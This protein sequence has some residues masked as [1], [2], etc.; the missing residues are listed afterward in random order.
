MKNN[1]KHLFTSILATGLLALSTGSQAA[2]VQHS[3]DLIHDSD[4]NITWMQNAN[5]NGPMTW[6]EATDWANNLVYGGYDDWR[7]P[8]YDQLNHLFYDELGA[9]AWNTEVIKGNSNYGLFSNFQF[10]LYWTA[11]EALGSWSDYAYTYDTVYGAHNYAQPKD[12]S[13]G[14]FYAWAIRGNDITAPAAVPVPAA[15]W[16]MGS[17]LMGLLT[18]RRTVSGKAARC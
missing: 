6:Y 7:L 1:N 17:G 9:E 12:G 14:S 2:L 13:F 18:L 4:T 3:T 11:D 8:S 10:D 15:V 16:L 5:L